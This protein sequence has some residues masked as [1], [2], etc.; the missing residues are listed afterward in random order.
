MASPNLI[1]NLPQPHSSVVREK[2]I[3]SGFIEKLRNLKYIHRPDIEKCLFV[4]DHKDLDRQTHKEFNKFQESCVE[5]N[6]N[7][8]VLVRRLSVAA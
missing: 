2:S 7:T 3:E 8:A 1:Y 5:E 4:V 6:T